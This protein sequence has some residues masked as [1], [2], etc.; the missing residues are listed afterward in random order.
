MIYGGTQQHTLSPHAIN[1]RGQ[2]AFFALTS[3]G[4]E[5]HRTLLRADPV[6]GASPGNPV[7]PEANLPDGG[8]LLRTKGWGQR[9]WTYVDPEI[10]IGYDYATDGGP[11]FAA[12]YIPTP[13][14]GGDA[15]FLLEFG[16]QS[17]ELA[18]GVA[19][20]FTGVVPE[21][22]AAFR[23][24]GIDPAEALDPAGHAFVIGLTFT[25][26]S[27]NEFGIKVVPITAV[28]EPGTWALFSVGLA[29][30]AAGA[31]RRQR[32]CGAMSGA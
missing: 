4:S 29:L 19:F 14:P 27:A 31:A 25:A 12:V 17:F 28:P 22:V 10:A 5:V 26:E 21:G 2:V 20:D 1:D 7:M 8:W 15:E 9:A 16:G 6:V 24:R 11:N 32:R 30:C 13:L 23:I 3:I 18:A